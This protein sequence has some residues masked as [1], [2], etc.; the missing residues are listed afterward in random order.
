MISQNFAIAGMCAALLVGAGAVA[1]LGYFLIL[2]EARTRGYEEGVAD[3]AAA[4]PLLPAED[5]AMAAPAPDVDRGPALVG[6]PGRAQA[7]GQMGALAQAV[8]AAWGAPSIIAGEVTESFDWAPTER[9]ERWSHTGPRKTPGRTAVGTGG[10]RAAD[11][12]SARPGGSPRILLAQFRQDVAAS[13]ARF[14]RR[15][16]ELMAA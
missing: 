5:M 9:L 3:E 8:Q 4:M 15:I 11:P 14:D 1:V 10:K 13:E 2:P 12:V 16:R 7:A 6:A